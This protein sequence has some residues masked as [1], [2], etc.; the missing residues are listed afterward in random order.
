[1]TSPILQYD[2]NTSSLEV[3]SSSSG[4]DLVNTGVTLV[5]D[6]EKGSVASFDG[7][8]YLTLASASVPSNLIGSSARTIVCLIKPDYT[9]GGSS[10]QTIFGNGN[11]NS[12]RQIF[13]VLINKNNSDAFSADFFGTNIIGTSSLLDGVWYH[14][15]ITYGSSTISTYVNGILENS[16]SVSLNT[17]ANDLYIGRRSTDT[18]SNFSGLMTDL[19]VYGSALT[20]IEIADDYESVNS[21][22]IT[23]WSTFM[24]LSWQSLLS[25]TSYRMTYNSGTGEVISGETSD[26]TSGIYNLEPETEYDIKVYSSIDDVNYVIYKEMTRT[27]LTDTFENSNLVAF[28]VDGVCDLTSLNDVTRLRLEEY[29]DNVLVTGDEFVVNNE[30]FRNKYFRVVA[31]G[32]TS[33]IPL[34]GSILFP[35]NPL[36]GSS[37][38]AILELSDLSNITVSYDDSVNSIIVDGVTYY[39]GD[40]FILDGQK[41][42]VYDI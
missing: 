13:S 32:G 42:T 38:N 23:P 41:V 24:E 3:D 30:S 39:P 22:N 18:T 25:T 11:N 33:S 17:I 16:K 35:F 4:L 26:I 28:V 7:S 1:M 9:N 2:F 27:T 34:N 31:R 8:S 6:S 14:V 40:T 19:R 20:S 12:A 29:I 10:F 36:E 21:F 15:A 5:T 37:Q